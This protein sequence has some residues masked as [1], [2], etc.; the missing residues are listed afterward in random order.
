MR[1]IVWTVAMGLVLIA[2]A[3]LVSAPAV[4]KHYVRYRTYRQNPSAWWWFGPP[5]RGV[6]IALKARVARRG[7]YIGPHY[8][9]EMAPGYHTNG[10]GI[11]IMR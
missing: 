6:R 7:Q 10:P 4:A 2:G 5:G 11:G 9:S 3:A 1:G 8:R